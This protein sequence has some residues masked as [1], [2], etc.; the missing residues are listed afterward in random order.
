[1]PDQIK[2]VNPIAPDA[3]LPSAIVEREAKSNPLSAVLPRDL[4]S[5]R[6]LIACL[7]LIASLAFASSVFGDFVHDDVPQIRDNRTLG[8]WD[9][10]TLTRIFAHDFWASLRP[11][12]AGD[13]LDSLYYR[14]VFS[15]LLMI[16]FEV[17]GTSS[18]GWHLISIFLHVVAVVMAFFVIKESLNIVSAFE[19]KEK[20][21]LAAFAAAF[22]AAHP[23]Q[24]E[25]VS[26]ISGLVGPLSTI[27]LLGAFYCYLSY[28]SRRSVLKILAAVFLF[29]I[30]VLAKESACAVIPVVMAYELLIFKDRP[31][32]FAKLKSAIAQALPFIF[33]AFGYF[34]LRYMAL[35]VLFGRSINLNFP[36]DASITL[37]DNLRT[38]PALLVAYAKIV[39]CP[40]DLSLMYNFGYVR[41]F[42]FGSFW[43]PL[44]VLLVA[45]VIL[46]RYSRRL[47]EIK[48]ASIW[49]V[50]PLLPHLNTRVFVSDEII[51]DRYLYLSLLGVGLLLAVTMAKIAKGALSPWIPKAA[52]AASI[53]ILITL[54]LLTS[55]Q[56][57]IYENGEVLWRDIAAHAPNSRIARIAMGLMAESKQD[58]AEAL[59]EYEAALLIN[60]NIIDALNNSAFV[61]ARTGR[62]VEAAQNFER[63]ILITPDK[64]IAH[65]NLSFAYAVMRRYSEAAL[66]QQIAI[67]LDPK[68]P[69]AEEWQAR[70]AQ[71]KKA[72]AESVAIVT[73]AN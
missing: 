21:L 20:R 16:G 1:M 15:L 10:T 13:K 33:V 28:R 34:A 9:K 36:D 24:A 6:C 46:I 71:L 11:E 43:L 3:T 53:V 32:L 73:K 56:S 72:E 70:L 66:E 30:S 47:P 54:S 26:W 55:L 27:F 42:G 62:W 64:A 63:I 29:S 69:R 2:A 18:A 19:E 59:R 35:G 22:F 51:H 61:Y 50:L 12:L 17:V 8:H 67:E 25:S 23:A 48:L 14:P 7:I 65:F 52:M 49:I 31:T 40:F 44:V 4:T 39:V 5:T 38:L 41:Y 68:G 57:R 58:P 60:P 45:S 37:A